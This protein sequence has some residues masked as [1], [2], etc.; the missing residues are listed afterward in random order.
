MWKL[1][2]LVPF[3]TRLSRRET[4]DIAVY[5]DLTLN[6][7]D[8]WDSQL[9]FSL[10]GETGSLRFFRKDNEKEENSYEFYG[11]AGDEKDAESVARYFGRCLE[12]V[13]A[14]PGGQIDERRMIVPPG[15]KIELH[16]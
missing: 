8:D 16:R 12:V 10:L 11:T 15:E 9:A 3:F 13:R 2:F 14:L 4:I 5:L 7:T 6:R 1:V